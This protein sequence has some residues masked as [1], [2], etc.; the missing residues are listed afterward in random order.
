[1]VALNTRLLQHNIQHREH[2]E[3]IILLKA[4]LSKDNQNYYYHKDLH[5]SSYYYYNNTGEYNFS[6]VCI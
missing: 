2:S 1:M 4:L 3:T 6:C 5:R